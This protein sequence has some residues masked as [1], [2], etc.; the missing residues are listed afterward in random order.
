[1]TLVELQDQQAQ[2]RQL[3]QENEKLR[4]EI[5]SARRQNVQLE[6]KLNRADLK[7]TELKKEIEL[8]KKDLDQIQK[9][10]RALKNR[11]ETQKLQSN[12]EAVKKRN[13]QLE[14]DLEIAK[15]DSFGF[16]KQMIDGNRQIS[17]L[18]IDYEKVEL[19]FNAKLEVIETA[20]K[21]S[22]DLKKQLD[23]SKQ[24]IEKLKSK[25]DKLRKYRRKRCSNC[26][27][28]VQSHNK[29]ELQSNTKD[30]ISETQNVKA[31]V[32]MIEQNIKLEQDLKDTVHKPK[33]TSSR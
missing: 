8:N 3:R 22:T 28:L 24:V 10:Y 23:E 18:K 12:F 29:H 15:N 25:N 7:E 27:N 21:L 13:I 5:E 2:S 16:Q 11:K 19:E 1:M 14:K 4:E 20:T 9:R 30:Q 26:K 33:S 6:M 17:Q 31:L 32:K